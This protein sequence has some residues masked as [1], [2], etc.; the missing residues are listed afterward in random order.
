MSSTDFQQEA[1][2]N[3]TAE[4]SYLSST[5]LQQEV[6]AI[7]AAQPLTS[8]SNVQH[9]FAAKRSSKLHSRRWKSLQHISPARSSSKGYSKALTSSCSKFQQAL[10]LDIYRY[11]AS[12][13]QSFDCNS[14]LGLKTISRPISSRYFPYQ[15]SIDILYFF[16]A[17]KMAYLGT[18]CKFLGFLA[19]GFLVKTDSWEWERY[20]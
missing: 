19:Y 12:F 20:C 2:E 6:P 14:R 1:P 5:N 15:L 7:A 4:A 11:P 10:Q 18:Y 8:S 13:V 17:Q 9:R 3:S 16:V